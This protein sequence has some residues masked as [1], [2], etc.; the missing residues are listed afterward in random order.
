MSTRSPRPALRAAA[1]VLAGAIVLS[2]A[3]VAASPSAAN[4]LPG[5]T[6]ERLEG[7]NRYATA[8][9]IAAETF[10]TG[11][12]VAVVARGDVF[13]DALA[14]NYLAGALGG[15]LLLTGSNGLPTVTADALVDL[16]V[17]EVVIVGGR[18]AVST[19]VEAALDAKY[20]VDRLGGSDRYSTAALIAATTAQIHHGAVGEVNGLRT[21]ILGSGSNFPDVLAAAPLSYAGGHPLVIS[22]P[23]RLPDSSAAI[24]DRLDIEQVFIVGGPAAVAS[25]VQTDVERITGRP[26]VRVFGNTRYETAAA[27]AELAYVH[28]GFSRTHIDIARGDQFADALA[29]GPHA[30]TGMAPILLVTPTELRPATKKSLE[31]HSDT[32]EHGHIFGGVLAVSRAVEEAAEAAAATPFDDTAPDPAV[33]TSPLAATSTDSTTFTVAGTA[34]PAATVHVLRALDRGLAGIATAAA[35]TGAFTAEVPLLPGA[36]DF[37]VV[38][39]DAAG[40]TSTDRAVATI[41]KTVDHTAPEAAVLTAPTAPTSTEAATYAITGTAEPGGTVIVRTAADGFEAASGPADATTGSFSVSTPLVD[42]TNDFVVVVVDALGNTGPGA[43][44]PTI[45]RTLSLQQ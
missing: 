15:P 41:V 18:T 43:S 36:N 3:A 23:D 30:G 20:E 1:G 34:E 12:R 31:T 4:A 32:L 39:I 27:I 17:D 24:L 25:D 19:V 38:V 35:T 7:P 42:G 16:G 26:A 22:R 9:A 14:A 11:A 8:A 13:A 5:V 6:L 44:V 2:G 40:N 21:A 37:V 29:G 45:T 10:P 28:F 33:L